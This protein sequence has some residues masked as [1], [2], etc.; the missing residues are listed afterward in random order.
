MLYTA[1]N[2]KEIAQII[3]TQ[4]CNTTPPE[5]IMSWGVVEKYHFYSEELKAAGLVLK[6]NGYLYS[7]MIFISYDEGLDNYSIYTIDGGKFKLVCS[8]IYCDMIGT[9]LDELIE[10]GKDMDAYIKKNKSLENIHFVFV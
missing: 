4:L 1:E 9:T 3:M 5:V 7:G 6:V 10:T 2:S 8:N